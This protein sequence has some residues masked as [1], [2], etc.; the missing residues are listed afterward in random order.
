ML[1][2]D[3]QSFDNFVP[4]LPKQQRIALHALINF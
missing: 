4:A 1:D 2:Y 3:G